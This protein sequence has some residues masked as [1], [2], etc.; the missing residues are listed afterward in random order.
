MDIDL[1]LQKLLNAAKQAIAGKELLEVRC[2]NL[3]KQNIE[4]RT[5]QHIKERKI[6]DAKIMGY[7]DIVEALRV[8][9]CKEAERQKKAA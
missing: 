7:K 4:K 9:D 2:D 6:G 1:Y 3:I 8:Q 5:R